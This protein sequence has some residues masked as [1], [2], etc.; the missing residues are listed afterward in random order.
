MSATTI[1]PNH[2]PAGTYTID[3]AHS[4]VGFAVRHMGIATVRGSFERIQGTIEATGET[5]LLDGVV[6]VASVSTGD[7][8]RDA[9]LASPEFFDAE[10]HPEIQ[11]RSTGAEVADEG[12]A[13][14]AGEITI[15]GVTK[16]IELSG[17]IAVGGTDPWGKERI[18]IELEAEIDRRDFDLNW[19]QPLP[20]GGLLVA[21]EV[22]LLLSVSAVK[23]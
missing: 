8:Q 22:K 17:T 4:S 14:L 23:A 10:R 11:F 6:E 3:P 19:N 12:R 2:I 1:A 21:N 18:G 15:K 20:G 16:P 7:Q 9:H 5:P 13:R